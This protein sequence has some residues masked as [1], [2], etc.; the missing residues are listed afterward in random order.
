MCCGRREDGD[1]PYIKHSFVED[2]CVE[3]MTTI[4]LLFL[5][6]GSSLLSPTGAPSTF[7]CF[8]SG[9]TSHTPLTTTLNNPG[10][11]LPVWNLDPPVAAAA[12]YGHRRKGVIVIFSDERYSKGGL[13]RQELVDRL[14]DCDGSQSFLG[15]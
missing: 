15:E 3:R 8:S 5:S 10:I 11:G 1:T 6:H 14:W 13:K 12:S 9:N 4:H 2:A 7:S